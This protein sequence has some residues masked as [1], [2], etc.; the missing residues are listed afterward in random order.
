MRGEKYMSLNMIP[1]K[2]WKTYI[3]AIFIT[4]IAYFVRAKLLH[5]LGAN[6]PYVTFY[7]A[8]MFS[9]LYGGLSAGLLSTLLSGIIISVWIMGAIHSFGFTPTDLLGMIVFLTSCII[10]SFICATM[11]HTQKKLQLRT[12]ELLERNSA[13]IESDKNW[14]RLSRLDLVGQM[15]ASIGH[16][17]RNPMTTVRGYLQMFRNNESYI[18]H[19]DRFDIMIAEL[20]RANSIITE[21]LSLAKNK[22]IQLKKGNINTVI[23]NLFPLIQANALELGH[24]VHLETNNIPDILFDKEELCQLILNLIRNSLEATPLGGTI[25]IKTSLLNEQVVLS[26]HD[27]GPG[28]P[29]NILDQIGTPFLTTKDSGTGLGLSVCYKIAERNKASIQVKTSN[30]GTNFFIIFSKESYL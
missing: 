1:L 22:S 24:S 10:L 12:A 3:L 4:I 7:P 5:A 21:Y 27:T 8:V 13:L 6:L 9:A 17:V 26:V 15:A 25:T 20:D 14:A 2:G 11:H 16:E 23:I 19:R 30:H 18:A 28:I 29:Q